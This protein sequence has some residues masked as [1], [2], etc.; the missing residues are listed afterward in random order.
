[1]PVPQMK[2]MAITVSSYNGVAPADTSL[3]STPG[4]GEA[5]WCW[6]STT[7]L[8]ISMHMGVEDGGAAQETYE[9]PQGSI[10]TL[11]DPHIFKLLLKYEKNE[12]PGNNSR[13]CIC[14]V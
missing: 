14:I 9:T 3:K 7:L 8:G 6:V 4:M 13:G 2:H 10:L 1:M 5:T 11:A 12:P